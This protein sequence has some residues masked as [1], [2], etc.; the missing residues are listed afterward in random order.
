MSDRVEYL[1]AEWHAMA[2]RALR[3]QIT[4]DKMKN[5][6]TS[7]SNIYKNCPDGKERFLFV[8]LQDGAI[9]D[10]QVGE[11]DPPKAEFRITGDY[12]VFSRITRAE[13]VRTRRS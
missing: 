5:I 2:E 9:A 10:F 3:E 6:T 7:M 4:P 11:G 1:S 13:M 8:S 12:E